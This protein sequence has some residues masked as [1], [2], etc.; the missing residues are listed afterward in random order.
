MS[1][2]LAQCPDVV[3]PNGAAASQWVKVADI[4]EDAVQISLTAPAVLDGVTY[5]IQVSKDGI[6]SDGTLNNG[7]TDVAPPA[8]GKSVNYPPIAAKYW[9]IFASGN[10]AAERRFKLAKIWNAW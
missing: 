2:N 7:T 6:T 10:A 9:R 5:T 4:H 3:I 8:A 1:N